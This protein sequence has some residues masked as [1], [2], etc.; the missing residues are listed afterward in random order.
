LRDCPTSRVAGNLGDRICCPHQQ[1]ELNDCHD[2]QKE[3]AA[4]QGE[5]GESLP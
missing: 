2:Q 3:E 5:L 4:D 1:P